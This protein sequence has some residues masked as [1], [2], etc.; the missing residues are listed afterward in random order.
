MEKLSHYS[1]II[2]R[3]LANEAERVSTAAEL[4]VCV[5]CDPVRGHYQLLYLGWHGGCRVFSPLIHIRLH[6]G[7]VWIE[8]DGTEEGVANQLLATGIPREEIVLAFYS[9]EKRLFTEFAAA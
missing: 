9:P 2:E 6:K 8:Q 3:I 7:K 5:I 4:E 1:T